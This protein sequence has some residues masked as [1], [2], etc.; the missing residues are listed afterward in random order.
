MTIVNMNNKSKQINFRFFNFGLGNFKLTIFGLV[1]LI[2]IS[3]LTLTTPSY[4]IANENIK[5]SSTTNTYRLT[6]SDNTVT[7]GNYTI[8]AVEFPFA[9]RGHKTVNGSVYPERPVSPFVKFE[10]YKDII[11]NAVPIDTFTIGIGDDY[12]M[13]DQETRITI[14]DIPGSTSQDWVYE[15]YNPW[16]S[17]N[18]QKRAIPNLDIQISLTNSSGISIDEDNIKSGDNINAEISIKNTGEDVLDD[19]L[20]NVDIGQL[21][22]NNVSATNKLRDTIPQFNKDDEKIIDVSFIVPISLEAKEYDI[23]VNVTGHDVKDVV[24]DFN[25]SKIINAKSDIEAIYIEKRVSRNTSYLKE[26]VGVTLNIVNSGHTAIRNI[27]VHDTIPDG[28]IFVKD[29][30]IQNYT[31]LSLDKSSLGPSESWTVDYSLK[32]KEP[33]VYLLPGFS[34]NFSVGDKNLG[35]TSSE[36]GFRVFGPHVVLTKSAMDMGNGILNVTVKAKNVG[37]G[38]TKVIIGDLLPGNTVL[39]SGKMNLTISLDPDI[40]KIMSY[41]IKAQDINISKLVWPPAEATYYLDDWKFNTSSDDEYQGGQSA[42]GRT[43]AGGT[44]VHIIGGTGANVIVSKSAA[45]QESETHAEATLP[46]ME[47][48]QKKVVATISAGTPSVPEKSTPGFMSYE[49]VLLLAI[50]VLIKKIKE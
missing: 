7:E 16:V 48:E 29:G 34:T 47:D 18:I 37:N 26:Y 24:Y 12:I 43:P 38:P 41:T 3:I 15:Y 31:E 8:K 45:L 5:W 33:G 11:N 20:F 49:M 1:V 40:E 25:A 19:M 36:V 17:I 14:N 46:K 21:L 27:Q 4:A 30:D 42:E 6:Q 39:L 23:Q 9:V 10:L 28:L 44:G 13:S 35:A 22:F 2:L 50:I 32:P